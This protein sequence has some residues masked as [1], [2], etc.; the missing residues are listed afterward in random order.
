MSLTTDSL[1]TSYL[2]GIIALVFLQPPLYK[3]KFYEEYFASKSRSRKYVTVPPSSKILGLYILFTNACVAAS[4]IYYLY[5][6]RDPINTSDQQYYVSIQALFIALCGLKYL[7]YY[8]LFNFYRRTLGMIMSTMMISL[9]VIVAAVL[10]VLLGILNQWVSFAVM[11]PP[12][13]FYIIC[14]IWTINIWRGRNNYVVVVV[15][16]DDQ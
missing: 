10:I 4:A 1:F 16:K 8:I 3:P 5:N 9:T 6:A 7:W 13:L 2:F 14:L 11:F 12:L 15:T